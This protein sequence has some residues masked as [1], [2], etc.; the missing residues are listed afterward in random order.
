MGETPMGRNVYG[1]KCPSMGRSVHGAKCPWGK[2]SINRTNLSDTFVVV[3]ENTVGPG[4]ELSIQVGSRE[5]FGGI[6]SCEF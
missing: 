3:Y 4:S 1:L 5:R 6:K 2:K